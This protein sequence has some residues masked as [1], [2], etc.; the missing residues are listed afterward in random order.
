MS[1]K[2]EQKYTATALSRL[3]G[4]DVRTVRAMLRAAEV[5]DKTVPMGTFCSS[6][7]KHYEGGVNKQRERRA[8][9]QSDLLAMEVLR[10]T[11]SLVPADV[12]RFIVESVLTAMRQGM[13]HVAD[14][15]AHEVSI[16]M[17][18]P[19]PAAIRGAI[20]HE[21]DAVLTRLSQGEYTSIA[22]KPKYFHKD[23]EK[24]IKHLIATD[25]AVRALNK[26]SQ[27]AHEDS[28]RYDYTAT[29]TGGTEAAQ[30]AAGRMPSPEAGGEGESEGPGTD[31]QTV[32]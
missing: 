6:L 7:R 18:Q 1:T 32:G 29:A 11:E 4:Y 30:D 20:D 10:Q 25:P 31:P 28:E 23:F 12:S 27:E 14:K 19:Q 5:D 13:I 17:I 8:K 3:S 22:G 9:L 16:G 26:I 24:F 15:I 21:I 2:N